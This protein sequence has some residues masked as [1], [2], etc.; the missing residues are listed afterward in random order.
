MI[1]A[2]MNLQ[3]LRKRI[4]IKAKTEETWRFWGLYVHVC[5]MTRK[6]KGAPGIDGVTFQDIEDSGV[7]SFLQ[8]IR[9]ELVAGTY[10]P[11]RYR[12]HEIPKGNGGFRTLKIPAIRDRVVQG[13]LKLILEPIFE[14]DF[15]E[16][17]VPEENQ[18]SA[19]T[20]GV[21][22]GYTMIWVSTEIIKFVTPQKHFQRDRSHKP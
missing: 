21:G 8:Q 12:S 11:L 7:E 5:K 18:V 13:A 6:N 1:K 2:S 14:A 19:G 22:N 9:D 4:F 20:G 16:G 17:C 15:Q 3:D 10:R